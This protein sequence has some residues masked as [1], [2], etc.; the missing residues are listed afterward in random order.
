MQRGENDVLYIRGI[1]L[2]EVEFVIFNRWGQVVFMATDYQNDWDGID[3]SGAPLPSGAYFYV[4]K[5][6]VAGSADPIIE[7]RSL[8]ILR[9]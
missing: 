6:F 7:K 1:H 8:T 4:F 5:C 3:L 9:E 2:D